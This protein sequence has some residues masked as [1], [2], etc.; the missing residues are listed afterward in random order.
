MLS[1][2]YRMSS[3]TSTASYDK[4]P[5]NN[6]FWRY[7]MRRLT[8]EEM[9]DSVHAVNGTINFKMGGKSFYSAIPAEVLHGA[10]RPGAA[11]GRSSPEEQARRTVY[12]FVKR[13]V[14]DPFLASHDSADTDQACAVRFVTTVPTQ[15]LI[16]L[17]SDFTNSQAK[18]MAERLKKEAGLKVEDQIRRAFKLAFARE[19]KASE[20]SKSIA[21]INAFKKEDGLSAD[22]A[23]AQFCLMT[24]N[25]N[26]FAYLD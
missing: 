3:R 21:L 24:L 5:R 26:E 14:S 2:A 8:A 11:W 13:S 1:S 10:S 20:V 6:L 16:M 25:L 4:D 15:S 19:P 23:L 7:D 9:R 17:N 18:V 22:Q 12:N